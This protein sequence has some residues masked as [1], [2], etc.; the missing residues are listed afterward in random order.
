LT[1]VKMRSK[2]RFSRECRHSYY[3]STARRRHV[4]ACT[5]QS[6]HNRSIST[7][8]APLKNKRIGGSSVFHKQVIYGITSIAEAFA[9]VAAPLAVNTRP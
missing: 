4:L 7:A 8:A 9:R 1:A 6:K 5:Q 2:W 3:F